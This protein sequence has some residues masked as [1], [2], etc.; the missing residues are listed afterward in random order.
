[1]RSDP[2]AVRGLLERFASQPT[3]TVAIM[4]GVHDSRAPQSQE[5][6]RERRG[7]LPRMGESIAVLTLA[8]AGAPL[9]DADLDVL[10]RAAAG[11]GDLDKGRALEAA[12]FFARRKGTTS[13]AAA[14]IAG[15]PA[16][17]ATAG[18]NR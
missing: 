9:T 5:I 6:A 11:G 10:A 4:I 2:A 17:P 18:E 14:R 16:A 12:W 15:A 7:T 8:R 1:M 13:E 3:S